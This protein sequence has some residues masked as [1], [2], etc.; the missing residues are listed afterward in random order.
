[1][2]DGLLTN[3]CCPFHRNMEISARY[4]WM[5]ELQP[6]GFKWAAMAAFA[7]HHV[8]LALFPL[9]LDADGTGYVDL[10]RSLARRKFLLTQDV[11]TIRAT[12]NAI[13]DDIF[14]VHLVYSS[15]DDGIGRL[16]TLLS[17]EPR[18]LVQP[19]FDQ[20]SC[21]FAR[22]VSVAATTSFEVRGLRQ[23]LACFTSFYLHALPKGVP[24][25]WRVHAWP[26]ITHFEDRWR[27]LE[28]SVVPRF[29]RLDADRR[30]IGAGLRRIAAEARVY[31]S[32][33]CVPPD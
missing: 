8:R 16:R 26:R 32:I 24:H 12:N 31:A 9:R 30:S 23:E 20:L 27:W 18:A 6:A 15:A 21:A 25:A 13:F 10:P 7:S 1:M 19:N 29:R 14:W 3:E 22:L 5:H 33:P 4:A 11:H 17:A 2:V 28:T